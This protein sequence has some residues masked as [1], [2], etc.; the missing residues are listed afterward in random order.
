MSLH[1][2]ALA[3]W[4]VREGGLGDR[5]R[6]FAW[7]KLLLLIAPLVARLVGSLRV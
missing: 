7:D 4:E 6:G 2:A 5:I 3:H 1:R